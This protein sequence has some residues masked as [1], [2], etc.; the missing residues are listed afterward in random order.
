MTHALPIHDLDKGV[1][2]KLAF[3]ASFACLDPTCNP[4][5]HTAA[6]TSQR[7]DQPG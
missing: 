7:D 4:A 6:F 1:V 5:A 2:N 3:T